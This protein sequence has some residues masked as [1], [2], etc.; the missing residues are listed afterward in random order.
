[1]NQPQDSKKGWEKTHSAGNHRNRTCHKIKRGGGH[2]NGFVEKVN[3]A[4]VKTPEQA[5][6]PLVQKKTP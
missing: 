1:M 2:T 6:Q 3:K 5:L 4:P